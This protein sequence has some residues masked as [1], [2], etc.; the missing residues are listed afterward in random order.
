V[1]PLFPPRCPHRSAQQWTEKQK[2][3]KHFARLLEVLKSGILKYEKSAR[4]LR[5]SGF[6]NFSDLKNSTCKYL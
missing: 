3:S 1:P 4:I 5:S 2:K 6:F